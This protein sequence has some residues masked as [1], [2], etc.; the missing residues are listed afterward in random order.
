MINDPAIEHFTPSL[1]TFVPNFTDKKSAG[2]S[3]ENVLII[4]EQICR[5][6]N[7]TEVK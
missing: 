1:I 5:N 6:L 4:G 2:N 3:G 7:F